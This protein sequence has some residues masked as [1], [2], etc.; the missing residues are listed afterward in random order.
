MTVSIPGVDY[1]WSHPGGASLQAAGKKF[2]CR[3][4]GQDDTKILKRAEADDLAAH[5][6]WSVVVY[7]DAADR[8]LGGRAVGIGDAQRGLAQARAAGMPEDRPIFF[9]V[10]FNATEAQQTAINAY[11]DGA[12]S[13]IGKQ[14]TGI[15]GG[16]WPVKRALDGGHATWAW[17]TVGWSGSNR[18]SRM[19]ILQ[20][21]TTV[22]INGVTCD[23]DTAL[24]DDFGQWKPGILPEA[25]MAA[26]DLTPAS[27]NAVAAAVTKNLLASLHD[28]PTTAD[29]S[30]KSLGAIWW[31]D[32]KNSFQANTAITKVAVS[33]A[34]LQTAVSKLGTGVPADFVTSVLAKLDALQAAVTDPSGLLDQIRTELESYQITITKES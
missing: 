14:W 19:V 12:A 23:N 6:I 11:L 25:A 13:V 10:D 33:V 21:A 17:Q 18:D 8:A 5:G 9:A 3:Y 20:P 1:A 27:V 28:D 26:V 16:Y 29:N 34:A 2:V 7:E 22:K 15:Y 24:S 31:D 32:G 4:L 30:T